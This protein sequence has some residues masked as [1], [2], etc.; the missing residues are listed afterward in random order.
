MFELKNNK[1]RHSFNDNSK[2]TSLQANTDELNI[3]GIVSGN[4]GL[5]EGKTKSASVTGL[6]YR[7]N[8]NSAV[9]DDKMSDPSIESLDKKKSEPAIDLTLTT[10]ANVAV[11]NIS[12]SVA[13]IPK[14]ESETVKKK[15]KGVFRKKKKHTEENKLKADDAIHEVKEE[16]EVSK[17]DII[18]HHDE[19]KKKKGLFSRIKK[20]SKSYDIEEKKRSAER[21]N[22]SE[23]EISAESESVPKDVFISDVNTSLEVSTETSNLNVIDHELNNDNIDDTVNNISNNNTTDDVTKENVN[24][25]NI[26]TDDIDLD[27]V[28]TNVVENELNEA[29]N[30]RA[31]LQAIVN[32]QSSLTESDNKKKK[33]IFKK[34][35][36]NSDVNNSNI[37]SVNGS[38]ASSPEVVE[39]NTDIAMDIKLN[40]E[41]DVSNTNPTSDVSN[42]EPSLEEVS[43]E[44]PK[45]SLNTTAKLES[46]I[47]NDKLFESPIAKG[48]DDSVAIS[49]LSIKTDVTAEISVAI[50][51]VNTNHIDINSKLLDENE[52]NIKEEKHDMEIDI[53]KNSIGE[54]VFQRSDS[55][56]SD[57]S[58][59]KP[60]LV[61]PQISVIEPEE[62][63]IS[64]AESDDDDLVHALEQASGHTNEDTHSL[65]QIDAGSGTPTLKK[66]KKFPSFH[67]KS[68]SSKKEKKEKK[69]KEKEALRLSSNNLLQGN[70]RQSSLKGSKKNK[71]HKSLENSNPDLTNSIEDLSSEHHDTE[72]SKKKN[73]LNIFRSK[74]KKNESSDK[75][76][77]IKGTSFISYSSDHEDSKSQTFMSSDE[78]R[79]PETPTEI[80]TENVFPEDHNGISSSGSLSSKDRKGRGSSSSEYSK[81]KELIEIAKPEPMEF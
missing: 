30:I 18:D 8:R 37:M 12:T 34:K 7:Q 80:G 54:L 56:V 52:S 32:R 47:E 62:D 64:V 28:V 5:Y 45:E 71:R 1:L 69:E 42:I 44:L 63:G 6:S 76:N 20:R 74:K 66:K 46:N 40:V 24:V 14:Q 57:A 16:S 23:I 10:D 39:T 31:D 48:N 41:S 53:K 4:K 27:K 49:D 11:P 55:T 78:F 70:E 2:R 25:N 73:P 17:K 61:L 67:I 9:F 75:N 21:L 3:T 72:K 59:N 19:E 22:S 77:S 50:G 29:S 79:I 35:K 13:E 60:A 58:L 36:R 65:D 81:K 33:R 68:S 43:T 51:N 38:L 15:K 26:D